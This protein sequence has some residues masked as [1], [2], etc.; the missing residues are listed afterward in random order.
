MLHTKWWQETIH[1]RS[2][3]NNSLPMK[4]ISTSTQKAPDRGTNA[5]EMRD[6]TKR[7]LTPKGKIYTAIR[8]INLAVAP[9]EF[10]AVVGPTG[11]GKSTTL[12]LISGL[13]RP[14][15]GS[16]QVMGKAV[17]GIDPRIGYVFQTDAVFPWKSVL[18][19]VATGPIFRGQSKAQAFERAHDWI[20]RVG[21]SGFEN[22][23][24]HQLSGGMRKRVALAQTFINEPQILLMDEPF[25]ALDVQTRTMMED[26]LLSLWSSL[27]ASVVFVTHDLEEAISLAD[28]V[29]VLTSGPGTVK[30]L[31]TIDLPRPRKVAE[32][33]FEPRFVQLYQQ[34]WEDL[35]EEVI[36]SYERAK[37]RGDK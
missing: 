26:E 22:H 29:C 13:E 28:R 36:I 7:F 11:C 20:A 9:G 12:G 37:Q 4:D 21:L 31:Y 14:S 32:I 24:P 23:Y 34:I 10:V 30:G 19:N 16:V 5:I 15:E 33:R 2:A 25:S 27:S 3:V 17:Q 18:S 35:R 1:E 6:A 8:D